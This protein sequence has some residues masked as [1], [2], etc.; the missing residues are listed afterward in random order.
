MLKCRDGCGAAVEDES[1]AEAAGWSYLSIRAAWRCGPCARELY[2]ASTLVGPPA[3]P[4]VD[5][6]PPD[7]RGAL[8]KETASTIAAPSV[9]S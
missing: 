1:G 6:L 4:F 7:S 9:R 8:R 2:A 3:A 5:T